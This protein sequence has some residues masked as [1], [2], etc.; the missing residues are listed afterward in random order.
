MDERWRVEVT[1]DAK[2]IV[3]GRCYCVKKGCLRLNVTADTC[4]GGRGGIQPPKW[5][6]DGRWK[7]PQMLKKSWQADATRV[8]KGCLR[9]NVTADTRLGGRGGIQPPKWMS[10]GGWKSPQTG[11]WAAARPNATANQNS[12]SGGSI[13]L[14]GSL[15]QRSGMLLRMSIW[16]AA[17]N[18]AGEFYC[19]T[20]WVQRAGTRRLDATVNV[21]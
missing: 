4:L 20:A 9:L 13:Q 6:S 15:K 2:E 10:D 12:S 8:K 18:W 14:Q 11:V 5:M 17:V 16:G 19:P 7:S 1:A 21:G 3:A